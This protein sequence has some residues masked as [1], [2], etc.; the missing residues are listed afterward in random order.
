MEGK[1]RISM[2]S[3]LA[4]VLSIPFSFALGGCAAEGPPAENGETQQNGETDPE[5]PAPTPY[6][7]DDEENAQQPDLDGA[8]VEQ[9][10]SDTTPTLF[11]LG[12]ARL[13]DV[14]NAYLMLGDENCP[15]GEAYAN[16]EGESRAFFAECTAASG[17]SFY[18]DLFYN[19]YVDRPGEDGSTNTGFEL[20][21]GGLRIETPAAGTLTLS[22]YHGM[23]RGQAPTYFSAYTV[24]SGTV[25]TDS[26]LAEGHLWLTGQ[27]RG[28]LTAFGYGDENGIRVFGMEG[29]V[30]VNQTD[31]VSA[32]S[33]EGVNGPNFGPCSDEPHGII[34]VREEGGVWHDVIFDGP[35]EGE[36]PDPDLCDGC[37][38]RYVGGEE[39]GETCLGSDVMTQ[40]TDWDQSPW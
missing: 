31:G 8:A 18:G 2:V 12:A 13:Q 30:A 19:Q 23:A 16:A 10:I 1:M 14:L 34:S 37:G 9:A 36:E 33:F 22:G 32:I 15:G 4:V 11:L 40:L 24:S 28:E 20:Y 38:T 6:V 35:A 26:S 29:A 27:V 25:Q 17:A 5:V 39:V 3:A 7:V 21:A